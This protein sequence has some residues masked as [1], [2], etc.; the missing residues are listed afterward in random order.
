LPRRPLVSGR[1]ASDRARRALQICHILTIE[2]RA[3][4]S[5]YHLRPRD[6]EARRTYVQAPRPRERAGFC[7]PEEVFEKALQSGGPVDTKHESCDRRK[8]ISQEDLAPHRGV[9]AE[10]RRRSL[11]RLAGRGSVKILVAQSSGVE[12]A[13]FR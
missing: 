5:G 6:N 13:G 4:A 10:R 1:S 8:V 3:S 11:P 7:A 2:G 12:R 9:G